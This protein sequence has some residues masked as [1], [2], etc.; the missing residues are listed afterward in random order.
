MSKGIAPVSQDGLAFAGARVVLADPEQQDPEFGHQDQAAGGDDPAGV[1]RIRRDPV[2]EREIHRIRAFE[3]PPIRI[4]VP[5]RLPARPMHR[6]KPSMIPITIAPGAT[7]SA[8]RT[9]STSRKRPKMAAYPAEH[10]TD[11]RV[12]RTPWRGCYRKA[13][14]A[15]KHASQ[16]RCFCTSGRVSRETSSGAKARRVDTQ[17]FMVP[18]NRSVPALPAIKPTPTARAKSPPPRKTTARN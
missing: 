11:S 14:T 15:T 7:I 6:G 9:L 12:R 8:H 18:K 10:K 3:E 17:R 13:G 4:P 2:V 5:P 1:P 16:R